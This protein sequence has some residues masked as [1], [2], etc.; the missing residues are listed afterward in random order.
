MEAPVCGRVTRS[1]V[2]IQSEGFLGF[3]D[4]G[5]LSW[6]DCSV[7]EGHLPMDVFLRLGES[8]TFTVHLV[9]NPVIVGV[10]N[11]CVCV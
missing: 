5:S 11:L 2:E 4:H 10:S 1:A 9:I 3:V 6:V 8:Y 7:M